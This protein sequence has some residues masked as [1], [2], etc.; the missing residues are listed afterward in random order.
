MPDRRRT[1]VDMARARESKGTAKS[2]RLSAFLATPAGRTSKRA[3]YVAVALLALSLVVRQARAAVLRLPAYR[4]G[5]G[6]VVFLDLPAIA[7][8]RMRASLREG[9]AALLPAEPRDPAMRRRAPSTFDADV[10]RNLREVLARHP[11][12]RAVTDLEV[13]FPTQVRV[14]ASLRTPIAILRATVAGAPEG[15]LYDVPVDGDAV[16]LDPSAYAAFLAKHPP[17]VVTGLRTACPGVGRRW[18]DREDQVAE[19][20]AA[21]RIA[22]RM[23]SALPSLGFPRIVSADVSNFTTAGTRRGP[24]EVRFFLEDG[25]RV[26]WGRTERDTATVVGEEGFESKWRTFLALLETRAPSEPGALDV[27]FPLRRDGR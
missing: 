8:D 15:A 10:E 22:N 17:I 2:A 20:L 14:R 11:M 21:A 4:I 1:V 6:D 18:L 19:A 3:L 12:L 27:R 26:L 5:A 25:R 13:R 23:N 7:D 24:S 16:V 9:L